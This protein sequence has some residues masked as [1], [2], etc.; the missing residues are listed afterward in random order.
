MTEP[1]SDGVEC[2][3]CD[4]EAVEQLDVQ[5]EETGEMATANLCEE[6]LTKTRRYNRGE[7]VDWDI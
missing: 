5:N 2:D 3:F 1:L 7:E 4:N 6:H